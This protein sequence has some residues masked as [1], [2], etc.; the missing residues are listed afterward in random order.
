VIIVVIILERLDA[1][2]LHLQHVSVHDVGFRVL[3]TLDGTRQLSNVA[4][5]AKTNNGS[6]S[7]QKETMSAVEQQ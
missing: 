7:N 1:T 3:A 6:N 2:Q 5:R 4:E